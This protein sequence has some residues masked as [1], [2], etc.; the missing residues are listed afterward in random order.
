MRSNE[1]LC[2]RSLRH[3]RSHVH[4]HGRSQSAH[5]QAN[6]PGNQHQ[7]GL[8]FREFVSICESLISLLT[9]QNSCVVTCSFY[10][11]NMELFSASEVI[12]LADRNSLVYSTS[13][14]QVSCSNADEKWLK[15]NFFFSQWRSPVRTVTILSRFNA[16]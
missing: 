2:C 3:T 7:S 12:Q 4:R 16:F 13:Y 6:V 15:L 5:L 8:K 9:R 10:S 14:L 11:W 1:F